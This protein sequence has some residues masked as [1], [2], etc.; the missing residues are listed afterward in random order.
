MKYQ[1]WGTEQVSLQTQRAAGSVL[2]WRI[3]SI[4]YDTWLCLQWI[5]GL[6][7][8]RTDGPG[9]KLTR[10]MNILFKRRRQRDTW[11]YKTFMLGVGGILKNLWTGSWLMA[12]VSNL[13][14]TVRKWF[15]QTWL[16]VST[17]SL[18][19]QCASTMRELRDLGA[20][21]ELGCVKWG[22]TRVPRLLASITVSAR[23]PMC[24]AWCSLPTPLPSPPPAPPA[25]VPAVHTLRDVLAT[26]ATLEKAS[27]VWLW[28]IVFIIH[29]ILIAII[30]QLQKS[31][32]E[33]WGFSLGTHDTIIEIQLVIAT[34]VIFG[35][36]S[37]G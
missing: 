19:L 33:L 28:N 14:A 24:S 36:L 29:L 13:R 18:A 17:F 20:V 26:G 10:Q 1:S 35:L 32:F 12:Q 21:G 27:V 2:W 9:V 11:N 23:L 6:S 31:I 8:Q 4:W 3:Y 37:W 30:F 25:P 22:D 15:G 5:Q 7:Q 34:P 16:L